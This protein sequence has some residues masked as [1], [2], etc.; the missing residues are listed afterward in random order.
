MTAKLLEYPHITPDSISLVHHNWATLPVEYREFDDGNPFRVRC[1]GRF[2]AARSGNEGFTLDPESVFEAARILKD[3]PEIHFLLS[4]EGVGWAKI[5][6]MHT[7]TPLPN[8]TLLERVPDAQLES[9]L[10]A[11][12]IW[13]IPSRRNAPGVSVPSRIYNPL[14]VGRPVIICSE[15]DGRPPFSFARK[16]SAGWSRPRSRFDREGDQRRRRRAGR[17]AG[18]RPSGDTGRVALYWA[19]RIKSISQSH[20][21]PA[22]P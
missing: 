12:D 22:R 3:D 11:A 21:R 20:E 9:F 15:P 10:S 7:V 17:H 4:G 19:D 16:K 1:G 14:A 5:K 2:I 8:V 18:E 6:E 13:I